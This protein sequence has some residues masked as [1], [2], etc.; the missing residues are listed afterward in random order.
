MPLKKC[1]NCGRELSRSFKICP[2]CGEQLKTNYF[3][4]LILFIGAVVL[5]LIAILLLKF[6]I[7]KTLIDIFL[8]IIK[9]SY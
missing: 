3:K 7:P 8:S 6:V 2:Q 5:L 1:L 9:A 4:M